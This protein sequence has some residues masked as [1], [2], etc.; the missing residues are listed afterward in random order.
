MVKSS[1]CWA[2]GQPLACR[3]E[4]L[5]LEVEV[6]A[7]GRDHVD[8]VKAARAKHLFQADGA[9]WRSASTSAGDTEANRRFAGDAS[10][11]F[12]SAADAAQSVGKGAHALGLVS[13]VDGCGKDHYI[14]GADLLHNRGQ[15][16]V[17]DTLAL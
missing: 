16:I 8:H 11:V 7:P 12:L 10:A 6:L 9:R 1:R 14:G 4:E 13:K 5:D 3:L 17:D 2:G 15:V